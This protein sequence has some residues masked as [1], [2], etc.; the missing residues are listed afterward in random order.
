MSP[1]ARSQAVPAARVRLPGVGLGRL[2][3]VAGAAVVVAGLSRPFYTLLAPPGAGAVPAGA[4][5][6]SSDAV[7][8][9][10]DMIAGGGGSG[11]RGAG[12]AI[13]GWAAFETL[14]TVLAAGAL[15]SAVLLVAAMVV[16]LP[17]TFLRPVWAFG[18]TGAALV[19]YRLLERPLP[20]DVLAVA[21]GAWI[22][23]AG[24]L[25]IAFGGWL[26]AVTD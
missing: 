5:S 3:G 12:T 10:F 18:V 21:A 7:G 22:V 14:D 13:S 1:F 9:F 16:R 17:G 8:R 6:G 19:G 26:A 15:L 24:C 25:L 4:G 11:D 2:V 23:L 20:H